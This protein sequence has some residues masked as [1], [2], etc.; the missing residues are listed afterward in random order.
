MKRVTRIL[1]LTMLVMA[2][3]SSLALA[4]AFRVGDQGEA[5]ARIQ[6]QLA[7]L[8]YDV[9]VDGS[10]GPATASAVQAFQA[11]CGLEADGLVG[12]GTYSALFGTDEPMPEVSRGTTSISRRLISDALQYVGVPYVFG[13]TSPEYGFDCSG[14]VQYVF[15][16]S[17][18]DIPRTADYQFEIGTPV[19]KED[20]IPG[21]LVFFE[22]YAPGASHVGIYIGAGQFVHASERGVKVSQIDGDYYLDHFLCGKRILGVDTVTTAA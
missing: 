15:A 10:F 2:C 11:D 17:G 7:S 12:Q 21:D 1:L 16:L 9:A 19:S 3:C 5:V 8:G 14:F 20:L 6:A 13:G 4:S 18:I 22:T